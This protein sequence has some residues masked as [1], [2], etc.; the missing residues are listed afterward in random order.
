MSRAEELKQQLK[1]GQVYRREDLTPYS[2][3]VDR[4]LAQLVTEGVLDKI[5][6]GMYY[7]PKQSV[8]GVIPPEDEV[9]VRSFLKDDRFLLTSPN[10]YNALRVGTTQLYNK[11]VVYNHKRHGEVDL[12]G[13]KFFFCKTP[14]FPKKATPEFLLVDLVNHLDSLAEDREMVLKNVIVKAKSMD[15]NKL[16]YA[17]RAYG[18]TK[19][20]KLLDPV[21]VQMKSK[22]HVH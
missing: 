22:A 5:A 10:S 12:N 9:L 8:F 13:K 16:K 18:H 6:Q 1:P 15:S 7:Y 11:R 19:T 21:L 3:A 14:Y 2:N 20:K 17:V 4:H